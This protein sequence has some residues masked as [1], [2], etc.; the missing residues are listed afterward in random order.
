MNIQVQCK[1]E[2]DVFVDTV[3]S[4]MYME[5]QGTSSTNTF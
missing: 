1:R 5:R 4:K 2:R 3:Y